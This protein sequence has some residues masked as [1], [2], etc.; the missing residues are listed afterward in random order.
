MG[1]KEVLQKMKLVEVE[2]EPAAGA[3]SPTP[4]A[5]PARPPAGLAGGAPRQAAPPPDLAAILR[6]IP[7][8]GPIEDEP[9]PAATPTA[10]PAAAPAAA[11]AGPAA[12]GP[13]LSGD[14]LPD[15]P[16]VYQSAKITDPPHG[17]SALK[18]LEI[19]SSEGFADLERKAK[20][21][22]LLGFLRMNPAGPVPIHEVIQDAVRRDQA[23]DRFEEFLK[24]RLAKRA[25][26]LEKEN[27][28]LQAEI[29]ALTIKNRDKMTANRRAL[30]AETEKLTE[31]QLR[32]RVEE[33]RLFEAIAPFVEENPVSATGG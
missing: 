4:A 7:G 11:T 2:E 6:S 16:S 1:L 12:E 5:S 26:E 8:V 14:D 3:P 25:Q 22:T 9:K 32:K 18:I 29:D 21:A 17:F 20:A 13:P 15:F 10:S 19:L 31:W 33:K 24:Q 27:A 23:L 28:A 30:E